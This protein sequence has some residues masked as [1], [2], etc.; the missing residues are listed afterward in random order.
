MKIEPVDISNKESVRAARISGAI[1]GLS[2]LSGGLWALSIGLPEGRSSR[3][4]LSF[5]LGFLP[6]E[7]RAPAIFGLCV[8]L[9]VLFLIFSM[10]LP[11]LAEKK[12]KG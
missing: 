4:L 11:A 7:Y 12:R 8:V 1:L 5:V 2:L 6:A 10:A 9:G 3:F